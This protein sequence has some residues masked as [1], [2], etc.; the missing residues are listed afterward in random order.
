MS[1]KSSHNKKKVASLSAILVA[2][3]VVVLGFIIVSGHSKSGEIA[4]GK[5]VVT[6]GI[7]GS[8][9]VPIWKQVNKEL[10]SKHIYADVKVFSDGEALNQATNSGQIDINSFQHYAFLH[11]EVR[12]KN[13]KLTAIGNT[14]IQPLN[15]YSKK[16]KNVKDLKEGDK[17]AIPNNPTN[18]GRALKVLEKA[19]LIKTNPA[20]G[21]S[22][23]VSDITSNPKKLQIIEVDPAAIIK[24]LPNFAAGITNSNFV[25]ANHLNPS[26]DSIYAIA[27][28]IN[29][30]YN[31]PWIN[32]LVTKT[33]EENNKTY[34]E[35]VNAYHSK[36]VY[37]LI[38]K[39]YKGVS[40]PA[41]KY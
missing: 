38:E 25:Q 40:L 2:I 8:N 28:N 31:K 20:K 27:P 4:K 37:D 41:F 9:D 23:T 16:I 19:G 22:P 12:Q 35:V 29:D 11:Q 18:A 17:I 3:L 32:I 7:I 14:Y 34:K 1:Q 39:E 24:L 36:A 21:Y 30:S 33:S 13:Y 5:K 6:V 26:K 10:A 15:I